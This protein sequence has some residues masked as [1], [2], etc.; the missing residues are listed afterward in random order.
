M[1]VTTFY[2]FKGGVGRSMALANAAVEL[3][4]RGRRVLTVDFDLEAP[5]LDTFEVL[6]PRHAVPGIIDFVHEYLESNR[7]PDA[8]GF[9]ARLPG[10]D[11]RGGELWIMPS[12]AQQA[13]YSARFNQIDWAELYDKRDGYLLFEDLK[14]QWRQ[15]V[16]PDYVL[17]DSRTGHTDTGGI[18][19]RQLP[20]AV[21]ILFFPNEQNLR[22]LTKVVN[23]IRSEAR[24][25][26]R[27]AIELHFIMSN[28]PDMDDE[29]EILESKIRAF[30][31][32][33]AFDRDPLIVH[34][35][36]SLSLLNQAVFTRDRPKSRLAGQYRSIVREIVRR[37]L[38]DRD[39]ALDYLTR[40]ATAWRL[41]GEAGELL[42]A[43]HPAVPVVTEEKLQ[44]IQKM[45]SGDGEVMFA[46]GEYRQSHPWVKPDPSLF[47]RAIESGYERPEVYLAR[48]RLRSARGDPSG[49]SEDT[50]RV[51]QEDDVPLELFWQAMALVSPDRSDDAAASPAVM[52]FDVDGR[53]RLASDLGSLTRNNAVSMS[54]LKQLAGDTAASEAQRT[55]ARGQLA[56]GLI[57][58]GAYG[59]AAKLLRHAGRGIETMDFVEAFD[60]GM[61]MW[62]AGAEMVPDPFL[63]AVERYSEVHESEP[64][65]ESE[66]APEYLMC[67]AVACSATGDTVAA[68]RFAKRARQAVDDPEFSCW[69]YR[70]VPPSE[71]TS[72]LDDIQALI[73][74]DTTRV[75]RFMRS[76][77]A[78]RRRA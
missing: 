25:P 70:E 27:K 21:A 54:I 6:R 23:D 66:Q 53:L 13:T 19:T 67:M 17:I 45:H 78:A 42:R 30:R 31:N 48:A 12:G 59:E 44:R 61:A 14:A 2:S 74:G 65:L 56:R 71:F 76:R 4:R 5:G 8:R 20:D 7:A 39:G 3:A 43:A 24:E 64:E 50:M 52:S 40:T 34:R 10:V 62:G 68:T 38:N 60:Y 57:R 75:P 72:D 18:C 36:D 77:S 28:I 58:T 1:Y 73:D 41:D 69:R 16:N 11:D 37:N 22:G 47:D 46:V 33:L 26:R 63:R 55:R 15:I 29:D 49:A 32:Q 51:L 9:L 35:Y